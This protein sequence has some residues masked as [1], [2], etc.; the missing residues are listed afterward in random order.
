MELAARDL[1]VAAE[2]VLELLH[3]GFEVRDI[4][5]L[6]L[7][8]RQL[9]LIAKR[10]HGGIAQQRNDGN[11]ELRADHIHLLEAIAHVHD[12]R[13]VKLALGLQQSAEHRVLAAL[14]AA[15]VIELLKEI[16]V[17]VFGRGFVVLVFHLEHN[18]N[19]LVAARIALAEDKVALGALGRIVIF[20]EVRVRK[21]R[22]TQTVKLGLAVLFER[23]A[24]HL[25]GQADLHVLKALDLF[26]LVAN[27]V[28]ARALGLRKR[29]LVCRLSLLLARIAHCQLARQFGTRLIALSLRRGNRLRQVHFA[30]SSCSRSCARRPSASCS[31]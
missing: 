15:I 20:L 18:R 27:Q 22:H 31:D 30:I 24:H 4:D 8:L 5:I 26:I 13:V 11:E 1:V 28:I 17:L 29:K 6:L 25:G 16:L 3:L 2:I 23:L 21:R 12:S 10:T 19:D 9:L 14:L 7:V